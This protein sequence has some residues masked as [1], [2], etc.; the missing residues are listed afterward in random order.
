MNPSRNSI[1][2]GG[3][4]LAGCAVLALALACGGGGSGATL[5]NA[6]TGTANILVTDAPSDSWSTV[7]LQVTRVTLYN[8]ADHTRTAVA[9]SGAAS[10]NLVDL[11]SVGELL[12]AAKVPVGTYDQMAVTV[13]TDPATMTLIPA[14]GGAAL[15]PSQ[16]HVVGGGVMTV[17][18]DPGLVVSATGSNAVQVDF[19][20]SHPLFINQLPSGDV[21]VNFRVKHRPNPALLH[22]IALHRSLGSVT[23]VDLGGGTFLEHTA[24]G[25]DLTFATDASTRFYAVDSR[26]IQAGSLSGMAATDAVMVAARLQDDGSLYAV[27]VWYCSAASAAGLPIGQ[28]LPE[29]HV[30]SV[31]TGNNRMIVDNA[32][33]RPRI[34]T[35]D[36]STA[37]TFQQAAMGTGVDYLA[38]IR[39]GFKVAVTVKDPLATPLLATAVNIERA[40]DGGVIDTSTSAAGLVYGVPGNLRSYPFSATFSW[41]DFAQPGNASTDVSAFLAA[42][43]G[44]GST[45]VA[46]VSSLTWSNAAWDADTA[47]LLPVVLPPATIAQAYDAGT[48]TMQITYTDPLTLVRVTRTLQLSAAAGGGQTLV[49]KVSMQAAVTSAGLELPANWAADLTP[50][51]QKVWVSVVPQANGNLAAYSV[52]VLE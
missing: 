47:I 3:I 8:K 27:R 1:L 15:S 39:R 23:S 4:A 43:T 25:R 32:D 34:V 13:N 16:I 41:C 33:G 40:V 7:Q 26:P 2:S 49:L 36:A 37:F 6:P 38:D 21:T 14:G 31:D 46:G 52:I 10:I 18:L 30:V 12:A 29:G 48:G 35:V 20:L 42:L 11:D 44:A 28:W 17:A 51:A 19:D 50:S 24:N 45:R 9:F 22:L 5:G